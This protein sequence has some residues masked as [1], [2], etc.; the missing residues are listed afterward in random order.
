MKKFKEWG[1]LPNVLIAIALGIICSFFFPDGLTRCFITF[2]SIFSH[3][4][5]FLIPLIIVGLVTPAIA[6]IGKGAGNCC[7]SLP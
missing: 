3:F 1:L 5:S 4:L 6:D 7:S 2:N